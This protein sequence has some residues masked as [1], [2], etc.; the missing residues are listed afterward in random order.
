VDFQLNLNTE[1]VE[2]TNPVVPAIV[3]PFESVRQVLRSMRDQKV[4]SVLVCQDRQL[5]GIFTERDALRILATG[6]DLDVP[7]ESVMVRNPVTIGAGDTVGAAIRK[8]SFGGFRRLPMV[9]KA[10]RPVGMVKASSIVHYLVEHF[11]QTVYTLPP[12]PHA[13]VQEREGA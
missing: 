11:P 10:G 7:V 8:M 3:A 4:S 5:L 9:D 13:A 2:M 12:Q 1:S 6:A